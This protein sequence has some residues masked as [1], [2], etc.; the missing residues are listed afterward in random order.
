M[1]DQPILSPAQ[2]R[3]AYRAVIDRAA[4]AAER[5]GRRASDVLTIAVTKT[6]TPDQIRTLVDLGHADLGENRVQHLD[7]R[8]AQLDEYLG[9]RRNFAGAAPRSDTQPPD[10]V[11]WHMIG[12][13]QRN[14]V[15]QVIPLVD[16]VHSVDSL[17]LAEEIHNY[18]ARTD[19]IVDVLI[20]VNTARDENKHGIA[21]PAVIHFAEQIHT[22]LHLRL[23]GL[24]TMA[25][26]SESPEDARPVFART[27]EI[28][29]DLR[30]QSFS[31]PECNVL[32]MGMSGDFEVAI[33]EGANLI[34][35]GRAIFGEPQS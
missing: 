35:V 23:R 31:G 24:M 28:F 21:P 18:A 22:M 20:Q 17:R 34:R 30:N 15:K 19:Q 25:P 10:K 11:R 5:S 32:S 7:Q 26:H 12:H 29:A 3:E 2:L 6:A 1:T 27:A 13:L 33:E 8:V 9:R 16:L 4:N 14:K